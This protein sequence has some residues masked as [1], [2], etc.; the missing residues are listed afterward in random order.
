ML[1]IETI[2]SYDGFF[3]ILDLLL[4]KSNCDG[5]F[6]TPNQINGALRTIVS[7]SRILVLGSDY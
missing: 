3:T 2:C 4:L 7:V 1:M 6:K 5:V